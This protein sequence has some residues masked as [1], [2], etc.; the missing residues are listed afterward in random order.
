MP[1]YGSY[2]G[3]GS[4]HSAKEAKAYNMGKAYGAAKAGRKITGMTDSQKA[5]FKKGY[6]V[7]KGGKKK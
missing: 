7:G 1:N 5:S 4:R 2:G 3:G 6:N